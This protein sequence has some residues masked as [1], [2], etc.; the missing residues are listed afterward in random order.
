MKLRAFFIFICCV[1]CAAAVTLAGC[2]KA[3]LPAPERAVLYAAQEPTI[4]AFY[5]D[6]IDFLLADDALSDE[7]KAARVYAYACYNETRLDGYVWF[8]DQS[9]S[10][11][12]ANVSGNAYRQ[13]YYLR[14]N[15]TSSRAGML[16]T[17][18]EKSTESLSGLLKN[19]LKKVFE[20]GELNVVVDDIKRWQCEGRNPSR[21]SDGVIKMGWA[22]GSNLGDDY[23]TSIEKLKPMAGLEDIRADIEE[24]AGETEVNRH[25]MHGNVNILAENIVKKAT[26]TPNSDGT[27]TFEMII[28][29]DVANADE[30]STTM[31]G[32]A[33]S[34]SDC[35]WKKGEGDD[36]GIKICYTLWANRLLKEYEV[37]ER[38]SG[39][40]D[41]FPASGSAT[42][43][44]KVV[45]S[46]AEE[47]L[48]F[49]ECLAYL[50]NL[51]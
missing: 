22:P 45:Y 6:E 50:D 3:T 14:L 38:W 35:S 37:D 11:S 28:D 13:E 20:K 4:S 42:S 16:Y 10:M 26:I 30:A 29:A 39:T 46:Y 19:T 1:I 47:D 36:T 24:R 17:Y 7:Q 8:S 32:R 43:H 2:W 40:V 9:G 25:F 15:K 31:L 5:A 41:G 51:R 27:T 33:N 23:Y 44:L 49:T 34:C 21:S 48:D 12:A 18:K